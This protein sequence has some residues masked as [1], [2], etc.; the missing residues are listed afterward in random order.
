MIRLLSLALA[1]LVLFPLSVSGEPPLHQQIDALVEAGPGA[2]QADDLEFLRRVTWD[3]AGRVPTLPEIDAF[4]S[5]AAAKRREAAVD[6][7]LDSA[8]FVSHFAEQLDVM[9]MERRGSDDTWRSFLRG[10][11]ADRISWEAL[12]RHIINPRAEDER[13]RGAAG[14]IVKRLER[15][16]QNPSDMPGLVR[17]VGRMFLGVDVQCAQCHD[18]LFVDDYKQRDYQGLF[19]FLGQAEIRRDTTFPAVSQKLLTGKVEFASVF[20]GEQMQTGPRI[21]GGA[22]LAIPAFPRGEEY[23]E[24]PDRKT[25]FPGVPK[26]QPLAQLA[27]QLTARET[28]AFA[29][30]FANRMWWLLM[31]RGLV[32]PLDLHHSDNPP[33]H[34]ELLALLA[35]QSRRH[36]F[37]IRW[38]LRELALTNVYQRSG[39]SDGTAG[40]QESAYQVAIERPLTAEQLCRGVTTALELRERTLPPCESPDE[41]LWPTD[42]SLLNEFRQAF[43]NPPMD[44]EVDYRPS[45]KAALFMMNSDALHKSLKASPVIA[46]LAKQDEVEPLTEQ[47]YL[48]VLSRRPTAAERDEAREFLSGFA[49][50]REGVVD[51]VWAL[52]SSTEF[53]VNH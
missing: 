45:V 10:A 6:R 39:R 19:A 3:F 12:S 36:E 21:P 4:E 34:P 47:A 24:P 46:E 37:D 44:P 26:F 5:T 9:L 11:V 23:L 7:L 31:G 40:M 49:H 25:R 28:D 17:D 50:R 13:R 51:L 52:L 48:R 32:H 33:S 27:D 43:A 18:H 20:V 8:D 16:G 42:S 1:A 41:E 38:L 29:R 22:E 30:N 53:L 14:F 15:Y 2:K 35:E